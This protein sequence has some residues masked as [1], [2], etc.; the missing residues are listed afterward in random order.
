MWNRFKLDKKFTGKSCEVVS[1]VWKRKRPGTQR[2]SQKIDILTR[3]DSQIG[4]I[5]GVRELLTE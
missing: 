1:S 3:L 2:V 5:V 4:K